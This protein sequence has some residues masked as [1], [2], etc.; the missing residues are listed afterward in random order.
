MTLSSPLK[1]VC[2]AG[3]IIVRG[4]GGMSQHFVAKC[5][6]SDIFITAA[7]TF[8]SETNKE[9]IDLAASGERVDG[10]VYGQ[11]FPAVVDLDKD[12]D[13]CYDDNTWVRCYKPIAR[14]E[15]Y[16][17]VATATSISKD[18]WVKYADGFLTGATN[19]NDAIGKLA[20]GGVAVTAVSG[21]EQ[22][23]TIEWGS[24]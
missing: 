24:D 23:V 15:I 21:Q 8:Q 16:A 1:T 3:Q 18:D 7:I 19:K 9:D 20:N 14:D 6:G 13:D 12:S 4:G 2:Q 17:T 22:V 5:N 10:I 11:A